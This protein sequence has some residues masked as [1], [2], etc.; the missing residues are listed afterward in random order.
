MELV[1]KTRNY[2]FFCS[3]NISDFKKRAEQGGLLLYCEG[4]KDCRTCAKYGYLSFTLGSKEDWKSRKEVFQY[5]TNAKIIVFGDNEHGS[6]SIDGGI[7][8]ATKLAD[9]INKIGGNAVAVI[10]PD[11]PE[12]GDVTDYMQNHTKE[13][14]DNLI[15]QALEEMT[16]KDESPAAIDL[17]QFHHLN[18]IGEPV[19]VYHNAI[20]EHIK[21]N[22]NMFIC[23]G[24][25]YIYEGGYYKADHSGA[26]LKSIIRGFIYPQFIKSTTINNIYNLFLQDITLERTFE[27]VNQYP[28]HWICFKNGMYDCK[29]KKMYAHSPKYYCINQIPHRYDGTEKQGSKM[30]EY[31]NFICEQPDDKEMLLQFI[32]YCL[33]K[34]TSQQKFLVLTGVGGSGKSTLIKLIECMVGKLNTSNIALSE[35]SQRFASFG[36]MAKLLNSCA[37]LEISALEDT[38]IIKKLLGEDTIRA[39]QK[40]KDSISF[41]SYAKMIFSTNELPII[42]AE[43]SNGFYRRLLILTMDRIPLQKNPNLFQQLQS[44]I[45]YLL[46]LSV[47]AVGRMYQQ[48]LL[49]NSVSSEKAVNQLWQDSDTVQAFISDCCVEDDRERSE[50]GFLY[51]KYKLFC[52]ETERSALTKNNFYKSLRVKGCKD[53]KT[54]GVRYFKG[55]LYSPTSPKG[56]YKNAPD[57]FRVVTPEDVEGLNFS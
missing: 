35:L 25:P 29:Q 23:G 48:E 27:D 12:H 56:Q 54:N 17:S 39:E 22:F 8:S 52:E 33:T 28:A 43:K 42:K 24:T 51:S 26:R 2:R 34:D 47:E 55:I 38:S 41:N 32:G 13:D 46:W 53:F 16:V 36:L 19:S 44:E 50:R 20:F 37:D 30:D 9:Y 18:K 49:T 3:G 14:L 11:V 45:D 15:E 31:L 21:R 1:R 5:L 4:E 6:G 10:P 40:G 7:E 57:G